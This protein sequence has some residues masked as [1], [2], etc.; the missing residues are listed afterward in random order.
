[1]KR[2]IIKYN[3]DSKS[4]SPIFIVSDTS[5]ESAGFIFEPVFEKLQ[6]EMA[7]KEIDSLEII[8]LFFRHTSLISDV[9]SCKYYEIKN[10]K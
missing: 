3:P 6:S 1:M 4:W 8:E 10:I 2:I 9:K 5:C 7:L